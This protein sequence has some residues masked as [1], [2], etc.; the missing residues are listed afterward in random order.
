MSF[1]P[2]S[3]RWTSHSP[4][5]VPVRNHW[6]KRNDMNIAF[7][8]FLKK[9]CPQMIQR[10]KLRSTNKKTE[11]H[12][13]AK[14]T[15]NRDQALLRCH[16]TGIDISMRSVYLI[17]NGASKA[18]WIART[19]PLPS[20][21]GCVILRLTAGISLKEDTNTY[22]CTAQAG[23]HNFTVFWDG[24]SLDGRWLLK[25]NWTILTILGICFVMFII[26]LLY[27]VI[28][29]MLKCVKKK[30]HRPSRADPQLME[31]FTKMMMPVT[32]PDLQRDP[33]GAERS[34]EWE[35]WAVGI[36][37]ADEKFYDPELF[38]NLV[39]GALR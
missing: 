38:A 4:A 16:V 3:K 7:G 8:H 31:W 37:L 29:F 24:N 12:I 14:P 21:D 2:G 6:N 1:D 17:G 10:I 35:H 9:Q 34:E 18:S 25:I 5:A 22:G 30:S 27:C 26:T 13:F 33:Q 32:S 11:L 15:A 36:T 28:L 39:N 19:G 23:G 20:E